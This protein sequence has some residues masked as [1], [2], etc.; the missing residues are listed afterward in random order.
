[1]LFGLLGSIFLN[2]ILIFIWSLGCALSTK[3]L[4]F[5]VFCVS[6]STISI[7]IFSK[8]KFKSSLVI[9]ASF[10]FSTVSVF[11]SVSNLSLFPD[12]ASDA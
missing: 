10:W 11:L 6:S 2:S 9:N 7:S 12:S 5:L 4:L 3:I 8:I 1:M